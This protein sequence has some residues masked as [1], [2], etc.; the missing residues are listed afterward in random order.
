MWSIA[1]KDNEYWLL[2]LSIGGG[3]TW[4]GRDGNVTKSIRCTREVATPN[5]YHFHRDRVPRK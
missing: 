1:T 5:E 3:V 2:G 4:E